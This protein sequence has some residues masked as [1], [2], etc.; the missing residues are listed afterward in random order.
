[1]AV[2]VC[3]GGVQDVERVNDKVK[4]SVTKAKRARKKKR[5]RKR[6]RHKKV[7]GTVGRGCLRLRC[8]DEDGREAK[9]KKEVDSTEYRSGRKDMDRDLEYYGAHEKRRN[10][11]RP[12]TW[13]V[14]EEARDQTYGSGL[15]AM[16]MM[17]QLFTTH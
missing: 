16:A 13:T 8:R 2:K 4:R 11:E 12:W 5:K 6:K 1:M 14:L 10:H 7:R 15:G 3:R 9:R 17:G